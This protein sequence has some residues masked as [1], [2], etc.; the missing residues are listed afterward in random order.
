MKIAIFFKKNLIDIDKCYIFTNKYWF[1]AL[2]QEFETN[3]PVSK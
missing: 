2:Y 3:F 1:F